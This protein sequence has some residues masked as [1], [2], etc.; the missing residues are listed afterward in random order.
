MESRHHGPVQSQDV[1]ELAGPSRLSSRRS[2]CPALPKLLSDHGQTGLS[3]GSAPAGGYCG[4][5]AVTASRVHI[6]HIACRT[7]RFS[8]MFSVV[9]GGRGRPASMT[10]DRRE[11]RRKEPVP[12]RGKLS[13]DVRRTCHQFRDHS[14]QPL[15]V[16]VAHMAKGEAGSPSKR[17]VP[18]DYPA[19]SPTRARRGSCTRAAGTTSTPCASSGSLTRYDH[20]GPVGTRA[21]KP[22]LLSAWP[23]TVT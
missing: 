22:L 20:Q 23:D 13:G 6:S 12:E 7:A 21:S 18:N 17:S 3:P 1:E 19:R 11:I 9:S 10:D 5:P 2:C 16:T 4:R 14:G 8:E 15:P